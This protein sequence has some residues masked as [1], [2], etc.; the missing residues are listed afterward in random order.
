MAAIGVSPASVRSVR[1][2]ASSRVVRSD[3]FFNPNA[4]MSSAT[5]SNVAPSGVRNDEHGAGAAEVDGRLDEAGQI[6]ADDVDAPRLQRVDELPERNRPD[7][8]GGV[9]VVRRFD[10]HRADAS[11]C[12]AGGGRVRIAEER[13]VV[14]VDPGSEPGEHAWIGTH[15]GLRLHGHEHERRCDSSECKA[16]HTGEC[17]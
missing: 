11:R 10:V 2:S 15:R 7:D 13:P 5:P 12:D 6:P 8:V 4:S 1:L 3:A 17:T 16:A 14:N 9:A